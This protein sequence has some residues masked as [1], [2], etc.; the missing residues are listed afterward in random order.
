MVSICYWFWETDQFS[1]S[2]SKITQ[3]IFHGTTYLSLCF[4]V[5]VESKQ[6]LHNPDQGRWHAEINAWLCDRDNAVRGWCNAKCN[7]N[8]MCIPRS[9][10]RTVYMCSML[11][12]HAR[13]VGGGKALKLIQSEEG[14]RTERAIEQ[15]WHSQRT[16]TERLV[17]RWAAGRPH[18]MGMSQMGLSF[19]SLSASTVP[20]FLVLSPL[21][22]FLCLLF[23]PSALLF[24]GVM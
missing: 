7:V 11:C 22:P 18:T 14:K 1:S 21:S 12:V 24:G 6:C 4:P 8:M 10:R 23:L 19:T 5:S 16:G 3:H 13:T 9:N 20:L 15:R 17:H 2:Y